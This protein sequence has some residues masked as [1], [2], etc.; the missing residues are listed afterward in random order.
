MG[1]E[2]C[3]LRLRGN[4]TGFGTQ[5]MT[6][7][8]ANRLATANPF[9]TT[10]TYTYD[11]FG[12]RA[13]VKTGTLLFRADIRSDG[14][15]PDRDEL[16]RHPGRDGLCVS[17]RYA[18]VGHPAVNR[19]RFRAPHRPDR[20]AAN[21][22]RRHQ[23]DRLDLQLPTVRLLH[24][25]GICHHV[26]RFPGMYAEARYSTATASGIFPRRIFGVSRTRSAWIEGGGFSATAIIT[27]WRAHFQ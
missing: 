4:M 19:C 20:D 26:L 7:N 9:G 5:A 12:Q 24:A 27:N 17:G 25:D 22:D 8:K 11:A 1:I 16:R 14:P 21:G 13:K 18:A 6:Y 3:H 23:N 15:P 10:S 2:R